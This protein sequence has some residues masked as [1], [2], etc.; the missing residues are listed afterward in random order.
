MEED[1]KVLEEFIK[2]YKELVTQDKEVI[3]N[4]NY[5]KEKI[6]AIENLIARNKELEI[7]QELLKILQDK[8]NEQT[9]FI[10]E[11]KNDYIPKS[12]VKEIIQKYYDEYEKEK[13]YRYTGD[14]EEEQSILREIEKELL[15]EELNN[16][17]KALDFAMSNADYISKDKIRKIL[18][19]L[20]NRKT[21]E[22]AKMLIQELLEER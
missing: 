17:I 19:K 1:I 3:I 8:I 12:K 9:I 22:Y 20:E 10:N 6:Q 18:Q 21:I 15:Q 11:I 7:K 2:D 5:L 14:V 13:E 4:Y 16:K